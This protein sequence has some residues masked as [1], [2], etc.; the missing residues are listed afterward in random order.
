MMYTCGGGRRAAAA[1]SA[2]GRQRGAAQAARRAADARLAVQRSGGRAADGAAP[3][4]PAAAAW[5]PGCLAAWLRAPRRALAQRAH[6]GAVLGQERGLLHR[7]VAAADHGDGLVAEDGRGAV[8]DGAGGDALVPEAL[9]LIGAGEGE[10]ARNGAGGDDHGLGLDLLLLGEDLEGALGEVHALHGLGEYLRAHAQALLAHAVGEI[11]A[12]DALR[13]AGEVLHVG[14][15]GQLAAR[16]DAVGQEALEEHRRQLGARG[17]DRGRVRGGAGADDAHLGGQLLQRAR[18]GCRWE[19]A[20][21][22]GAMGARAGRCWC[23][24]GDALVGV[25]G[26]PAPRRAA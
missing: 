8:A 4:A 5:L 18:H 20:G 12:Q 24:A 1:G 26:A 23:G 22:G 10:A 17:V 3:A 19:R 21:K 13:E 16:R 7:R 14:G 9:L 15:G 11:H 6:L 2:A 25:R